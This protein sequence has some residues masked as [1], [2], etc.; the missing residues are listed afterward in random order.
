MLSL[1]VRFSMMVTLLV[2]LCTTSATKGSVLVVGS[3]NADIIVPVSRFPEDG[4]NI[5]AEETAESGRTYAGGKGAIQ[6]VACAKLVKHTPIK[7]V[8]QFGCDPNGKML[9]ET[10]VENG[11]DI[12]LSMDNNKPSGMG[13]VFLKETGSVSAI[14]VGAA[15]AHW[16]KDLDVT[17]FFSGNDVSAVML[18]MEIPQVINE[19]VKDQSMPH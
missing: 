4:E 10:L 18:Q 17:S 15:N 3:T 6:A 13:V 9:K 16:P 14:V 19:A 11:V 1:N 7:F 8:T 12:R 2:V 5:V